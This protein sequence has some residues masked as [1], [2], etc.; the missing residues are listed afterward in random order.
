MDNDNFNQIDVNVSTVTALLEDKGI[1]WGSYQQHMPFSGYEGLAWINQDTK[2][3]DYVRKHNPPIIYDWNTTP[4]RLTYQK[5]FTIFYDDLE[6]KTLPQWM[7][8]TPNMTNDGH[9]TSV[10]AAG[11]FSREFLTP[12]LDNE[13]F[14]DRTLILLTFDENESSP[15]ANRVM[16]ILLG[17]AVPKHLIGTSDDHYYVRSSSHKLLVRMFTDASC[18]ITTAKSALLRPTGT[19]TR[20]AD[21]T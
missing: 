10:T 16:S 2:A 19:S 21:G 14:M 3:N 11:K 8:I 9:D 18:R 6:H 12:L 5:N 13:Y 4:E 20:S 17:G 15:K 1:S 7:F